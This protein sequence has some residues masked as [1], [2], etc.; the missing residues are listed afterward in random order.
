MADNRD[1]IIE[2]IKKVLELSKNNPSIEEARSAAL[3]AQKLMAEY[4]IESVDLKDDQPDDITETAVE[5]GTGNK[6]KYSLSNIVA[7]NFRCKVYVCGKDTIIF[8]GYEVDTKI[9]AET[10]RYLFKTGNKGA[11]ASYE[12]IKKNVKSHGMYFDGKGIRNSY[13]LG[14]MEGIKEGLDNQCVALM[15]VVPKE[16]VN[17][18]EAKTNSFR[19]INNAFSYRRGSY[20][21]DAKA[22]GRRDG[23]NAIGSRQ[24]AG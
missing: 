11:S 6:W 3:K 23:R 1:K 8:Y 13:L 20:A 5:V 19:R 7:K 12:R 10:F 17:G 21:D 22:D 9:A 16:V 18:F 15:I 24:L 14:F 4:H 2:K